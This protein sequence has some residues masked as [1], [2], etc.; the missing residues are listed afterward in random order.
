[1]EMLVAYKTNRA[2]KTSEKT[3]E[4]LQ[5]IADEYILAKEE[6]TRARTKIQRLCNAGKVAIFLLGEMDKS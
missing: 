2:E 4:E 5:I 6:F 1:M 3:R